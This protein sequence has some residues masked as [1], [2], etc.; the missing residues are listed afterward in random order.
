MK[1]VKIKV[2]ISAEQEGTVSQWL[3]E[4]EWLWNQARRVA[5]HSHCIEWYAWAKK[6]AKD[7]KSDFFGA[8]LSDITQ[9]PLRLSKRGAWLGAACQIAVG[10]P[11]FAK[12]KDASPIAYKD[13]KKG[14]RYK[15]AV[16][17]VKGDRPYE[18]IKIEE[19]KPIEISNRPVKKVADL[20][21]LG[22]LNALRA[23]HELTPVTI[24]S[25][26]VGGLLKDFQTS[27][28]AYLD[29]SLAT[30]KQPLYKDGR[31]GVILTLSNAQNPPKLKEPKTGDPY[32]FCAGGI[33]AYPRDQHWRKRLGDMVP[34]SYKMTQ[35]PSGWYLCVSVATPSEALIPT[36]KSRKN[37]RSSEVKKLHR[38]LE[39][40]ALLEVVNRDEEFQQLAKNLATVEAM[41]EQ[42]IYESSTAR[43]TTGRVAGVDPGVKAIVAT[44]DEALFAPN[45]R[46]VRVKSHISQLQNRLDTMRNS[47]DKRQGK[48]W[49]KGDRPA[50]QNENKLQQQIRR[51][52]ER[53]ANMSNAFNH[54][55]ST[56]L[57][58]TYDKIAWEDTKLGNMTQKAK[59]VLNESGQFYE[60]NNAAAKSGLSESLAMACIGD[61]KAKTQQ[62]MVAARKRFVDSPAPNSSKKCHYCDE[63]GNRPDQESFYCLNEACKLFDIWQNADINA[64]K[65]H[66]KVLIEQ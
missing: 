41:R 37:R 59:P 62:K 28:E 33:N 16:K 31:E 53:S 8:D 29:A 22:L 52:H 21:N 23:S 2:C 7:K 57:A 40:K 12:D 45:H 44:S 63:I 19:Y 60:Q 17:L 46:R 3:K 4:L 55:L 49:K 11:Y 5:L 6:K 66:Y 65:N 61:L 54:K 10:G 34:R 56:R 30:R 48:V 47:N 27:W 64:A 14:V 35:K 9:T 43:K 32:F 15:P 42:E 39:K 38:G 13:G 20:D 1:T 26:Y 58:R 24:S 36:L 51:L 50:T 25:D 18:R